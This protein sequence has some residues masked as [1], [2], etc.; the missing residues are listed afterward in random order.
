ML[1]EMCKCRIEIYIPYILIHWIFDL[2]YLCVLKPDAIYI[3]A[4][5]K[6]LTFPTLHSA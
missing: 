2:D 6:W 1:W 4:K 5:L 3:S